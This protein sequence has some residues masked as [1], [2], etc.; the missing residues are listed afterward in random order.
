MS[1]VLSQTTLAQ[2]IL[3][4]VGCRRLMDR[5]LDLAGRRGLRIAVAV[6]DPS[7]ILLGFQR[8]D[9]AAPV[10]V[11]V[12]I[13]KA[14]TAAYLRAPSHLFE[15]MINSGQT[16]MVTVPNLLPL[17]GGVPVMA[18]GVVCGAVGISG[19]SGEEDRRLAED[20]AASFSSDS[21]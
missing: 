19:G 12:A 20:V 10:T 1:V 4:E 11:D 9:G 15:D 8:R 6:T 5:A 17:Q 14:R 7:G 13:G 2:T 16:A 21:F 18:D 3:G